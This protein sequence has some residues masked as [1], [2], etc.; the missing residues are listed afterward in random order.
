MNIANLNNM[1]LLINGIDSNRE[2]YK[3]YIQKYPPHNITKIDDNT[4]RVSMAVAGFSKEEI[5]ISVKE[6]TLTVVGKKQDDT[7]SNSEKILYNGLAFRNF[8]SEFLIGDA[9]IKSAT[10]ENGLLNVD[11]VHIVPEEQK[12]KKITIS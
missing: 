11:I 12:P 4:Y 3:R 6:K 1:L 9:E 2:F 8:N 10:L 5:D 7:K